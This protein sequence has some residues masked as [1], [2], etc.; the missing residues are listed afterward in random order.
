MKS[1]SQESPEEILKFPNTRPLTNL[2]TPRPLQMWENRSGFFSRLE[3]RQHQKPLSTYDMNPALNGPHVD[4]K[5]VVVIALLDGGR[6]EDPL[7]SSVLEEL[8]L[9]GWRLG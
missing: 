2:I 9:D 6:I 1:C 3:V 5:T 4:G 8:L 7:H